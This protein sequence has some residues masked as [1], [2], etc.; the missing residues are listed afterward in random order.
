MICNLTFERGSGSPLGSHSMD[1][2]AALRVS[3]R[4]LGP[5][6]EGAGRELGV[7][8][9]MFCHFRLTFNHRSQILDIPMSSSMNEGELHEKSLKNFK[10]FTKIHECKFQ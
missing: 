8:R 2:T 10:N 9:Y 3:V 1:E 4:S 7:S 6:M 5:K